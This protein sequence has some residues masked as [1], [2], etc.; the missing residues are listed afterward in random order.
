L[1]TLKYFL[2]DTVIYGLASVLA[3]LINFALIAVITGVF[4]TSEFS[5]QTTWYIYAAF[6][7]VILTLGL[8]TSFFRF[9]STENDKNNVISSSFILLVFTS[10]LFLILGWGFSGSLT[11]FFKFGDTLLLHILMGVTFLDTLVVIPFALLR[12]SGRPIKFMLIK[13][14]NVFILV[15]ANIFLLIFIPYLIKNQSTIPSFLGFSS[16]YQP[17]VI[18]TF[19]ANLIASLITF[20]FLVPEVLKIKWSWDKGL[21][22]KL[23]NYGLPIMVGGL[24]YTIN[25]NAD[26][27]IIPDLISE[28]ANGIYA[29][30]YKLGV[31]MTLYITAFRMGAEPFFFNHAKS[32]NAKEKYSKIM[33]WFVIFG[34]LF[35]LGV[36][37]FIDL[38]ASIFLR[39]DV[40]LSGLAIVPIILLANLFSGIY[41][42]LSIWY[43]LTDKTTY[44]M[45][46]SI[47]GA[48]ITIISL[49]IFIP[50]LGIYGG[51]VAT[52]FTYLSMVLISGFL[53]HK[54]Y[55]VPYEIKKIS[56]TILL[57]TLLCTVSFMLMRGNY[58]Y[59]ILLVLVYISLIYL[60]ENKEIRHLL[61]K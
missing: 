34:C 50:W 23:L 57:T 17:D 56:L 51:A 27:L 36:V 61:K 28:D 21:V 43:K 18:H 47:I 42:N 22:K 26:K 48:L 15:I 19:I 33:T 14:A 11:S 58:L 1:S 38:I 59:N 29:A 46:I 35:M 30:C 4:N 25:E 54:Y 13:L 10:S 49:Y 52:L 40:Y 12:V 55:P 3:R 24:A 20:F 31:F 8:E 6:I 9:Y 7:N 45:Y 60:S 53:G 44:G 2:K 37:G 39:Q 32:A 5:L 16:T 41:I